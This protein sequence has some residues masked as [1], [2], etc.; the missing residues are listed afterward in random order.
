MVRGECGVG[1][2]IVSGGSALSFSSEDEQFNHHH[3]V[4]S[5]HFPGFIGPYLS[6]STL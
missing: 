6:I 4:V 1:L 2:E 3:I 5:L